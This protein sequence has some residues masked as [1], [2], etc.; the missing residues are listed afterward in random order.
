MNY[1]EKSLR[2]DEQVVTKAKISFWWLVPSILKAA[3]AVIAAV[4]I[5]MVMSNMVDSMSKT[6]NQVKDIFSTIK[7]G[8]FVLLC[9]AA[10][11]EIAVKIIV[12]ITT[13]LVIT[14]KRVLGKQGIVKISTMDVP[15]DKVDNVSFD[16][17]FWGN[18]FHFYK[19]SVKSTSSSFYFNGISNAQEFKNSIT[20]A[21]DK[22]AEDLRKAQAAELAAAINS[23]NN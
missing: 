19:L 11:V 6:A 23:K 17:G 9:I 21:I 2:R 12:I 18:I 4:I 16:G 1:V 13:H 10:A 20:D 22:R 5:N 3:L 15:I 7:T 8:I 14:N